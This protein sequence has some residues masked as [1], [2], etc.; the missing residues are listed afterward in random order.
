[1]QYIDI[2]F[3]ALISG[4]VLT[5]F[6][7]NKNFSGFITLIMTAFCSI[8]ALYF[9]L[10]VIIENKII[11]QEIFSLK[12]LLNSSFLISIDS[13]SALFLL[14]VSL[15]SFCVS[16]FSWKYLDVYKTNSPKRFYPFLI[17]LFIASIGVVSVKD[18][19]F[20]IV[21]WE[22]MTLS[23]WFLVIFERDKKSAL[24]GGLQYFIATHVTTAFLILASVILYSYSNDFSFKE[25]N[26][27]FSLIIKNQPYLSH[28]IL[29][30]IFIA[31]VTKAGVLPFGFWLPNT[32]P[33]PPS[34]AS[35]FFG[36]VMSKLAVYALFRFFCSVIPFSFHTQIWGFIIAS[37]GIFS[38]FVGTIAALTQ[39]EAKRL[40]SFHAIGQVGYM[41]LGIGVGL[42]FI[43]I[44][45]FLASI[46]LVGGLFHV[47]NNSIYKS[48]LFLNAGSIFYKTGTTDLNKVSG[49]MK[50]M[51]LTAITA[52][53]GSLSIAGVPPFNGFISKLLIF[54]SSIWSAKQSEVFFLIRGAFIVFGIISVFISAVTLASFLKFVNSAF[55]GKLQGTIDEKRNLPW[56]MVLSQII[57]AFIC[58]LAGLFP[59][60]PLKI[61]YTAV[62]ASSGSLPEFSSVFVGNILGVGINFV[63]NYSQGAWFPVFIMI[64]L[65]I[66]TILIF[67]FERYAKA[68]KRDV[69]T[70]YGGKEH[71]PEEV[72]YKGHSFYQPFKDL[73]SFKIGKIQ[74]KGFYPVGIPAIKFSVPE[75]FLKIL[76][77]D[78]W[79]YYPIVDKLTKFFE[80]LAQIYNSITE[81]YIVWLIFGSIF[82]FILLFY[83]SGGR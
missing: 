57:L 76:R 35:S 16:L 73:V 30:C 83:F 67:S 64:P 53:I 38:I 81:K 6:I 49:L 20:F 50:V 18:L 55:M 78:E 36:G 77:V 7:K 80:F 52:L 9:S 2:S 1:M 74:F 32:Y 56:S 26:K 25:I 63:E 70:W 45:P 28:F 19:L 58:L 48:L 37:F 8:G 5:S 31:F 11:E 42:Y 51:P 17:L 21:F 60:I 75:S 69:E 22:L 12:P 13:L 39:D 44:N 15:V 14:I 4:M 41:F 79:L 72:V 43:K 23:S 62:T 33:Q 40:M 47:F 68:R 54:E 66:L 24:K 34:S 27:S 82:I 59:F 71:A 10:N 65:I 61:I 29:F 3:L 46:A